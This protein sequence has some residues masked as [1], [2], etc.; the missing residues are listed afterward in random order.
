MMERFTK[1]AKQVV[2]QAEF[3]ARALGSRSIEAEHLLLASGVV[4]RADLI[5]ALQDADTAALEGVGVTLQAP[6][7]SRYAGRIR[8]GTSA[9]AA[10][11]RSLAVAQNRRE[12]RITGQHVA[13]ACLEPE[14]GTVPRALAVAGIDREALAAAL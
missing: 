11:E 7:P 8:F 9:K 13:L 2:T 6:P 14:R 10:L 1:E 5:R 12:K 3:E 4:P